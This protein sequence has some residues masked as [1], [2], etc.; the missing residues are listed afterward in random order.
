MTYFNY[1]LSSVLVRGL[2][3]VIELG[4]Q[5][6]FAS[7][8]GLACT[9]ILMAN[10]CCRARHSNH[11]TT[12]HEIHRR[13][14]SL[15]ARST[16]AYAARTLTSLKFV[17]TAVI[18]A[19]LPPSQRGWAFL[20]GI[21]TTPPRDAYQGE[22]GAEGEGGGPEGPAASREGSHAEGIRRKGDEREAK[23]NRISSARAVTIVCVGMGR[24][25]SYLQ[26]EHRTATLL[27]CTTW[28]AQL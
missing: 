27:H 10:V 1:P 3:R 9:S 5:F 14:S 28:V 20:G 6:L 24:D 26:R 22:F 15:A 17:D 16:A 8:P 13:S 19:C 11:T 18:G 25:V 2:V 21:D 7:A 4:K 12:P 23:P